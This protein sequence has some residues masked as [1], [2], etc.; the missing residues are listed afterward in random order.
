MTNLEPIPAKAQELLEAMYEPLDDM[1][2]YDRYDSVLPG[3]DCGCGGEDVDWEEEGKRYE[4]AKAKLTE[5]Y[6]QLVV[7]IKSEGA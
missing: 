3:C 5:L 4:E 1:N 7:V 2:H 6:H